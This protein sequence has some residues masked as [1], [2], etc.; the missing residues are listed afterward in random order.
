MPQVRA[1]FTLNK[2]LTGHVLWEYM[3][4]GN[5]YRNRTQAYF[6]R[7]ELTYRYTGSKKLQ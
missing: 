3:K 4:T 1:D 7:F 6:L 2:Q 5:F